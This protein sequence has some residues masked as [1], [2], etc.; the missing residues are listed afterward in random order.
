MSNSDPFDLDV[1]VTAS[2]PAAT[3]QGFTSIGTS[4]WSCS[5]PSCHG[6]CITCWTF[7]C[8]DTVATTCWSCT[9]C[10]NCHRC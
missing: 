6:S 8:T 5:S 7:N 2:E 10:D 1:R 4:C 3:P 9:E